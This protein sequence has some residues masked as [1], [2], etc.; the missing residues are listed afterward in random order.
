V[1]S[2]GLQALKVIAL[3][4]GIVFAAIVLLGL[5]VALANGLAGDNG[6]ADATPPPAEV[7][8][9]GQSG[10]DPG[11]DAAPVC[12]AETAGGCGDPVGD[13]CEKGGAASNALDTPQVGA[14]A[15]AAPS[16]RTATAT[17]ALG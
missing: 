17:F 16:G 10:L 2:F 1:G 7:L 4:L 6:A 8:A 11:L 9:A 14:A 3:V 15:A 5:A 12:G 13:A